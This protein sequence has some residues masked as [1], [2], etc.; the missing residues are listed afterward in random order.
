[1][2]R[3]KYWKSVGAQ[4]TDVVSRLVNAAIQR[5]NEIAKNQ[6]KSPILRVGIEGGGCSGFSYNYSLEEL[7]TAKGEQGFEGVRT[8]NIQQNFDIDYDITESKDSPD[9][10]NDSFIVTSNITSKTCADA[11]TS[12]NFE[13]KITDKSECNFTNSNDY[14]FKKNGVMVLIDEVS[15]P[16]LNQAKLDFIYKLGSSYFA[17]INPNASTK[18]GCGNSFSI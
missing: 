10:S 11:D 16:F 17:I 6:N 1:M 9:D 13:N 3:I 2:E 18:C 8:S 7:P 15:K 14:Y 5:I 4:P 12:D